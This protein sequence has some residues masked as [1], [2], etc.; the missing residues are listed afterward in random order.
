MK[1]FFE[2]VRLTAEYAAGCEA[3]GPF[4][5]FAEVKARQI[6]VVMYGGGADKDAQLIDAMSAGV[7]MDKGRYAEIWA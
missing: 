7:V 3:R 2:A 5:A 4:D 6:G 1:E